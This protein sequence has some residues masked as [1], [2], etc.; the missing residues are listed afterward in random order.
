MSATTLVERRPRTRCQFEVDLLAGLQRRNKRIPSKYFYNTEGSRLFERV[1]E[2]SEYYPTR[3][4]ISILK[5][6][7]PEIAQLIGPDVEMIEFGAGSLRKVR[8]LLDVLRSPQ[9]YTPIDVAGEY[10]TEVAQTLEREYPSLDVTPVIADF[11]QPLELETSSFRRVGFL[12]GSTIGNFSPSQA[13]TLLRNIR[14]TLNNGGLL[15]G[16]DLVK[17]PSILH[18]AYNDVDGVTAS[19]NK[20]LLV[21]ANQELGADFNLDSFMHH[22]CYNPVS[23]KIEMYLVSVE[24]QRVRIADSVFNF[25]EGEAIH[26]EDSYKY[27]CDSFRTLAVEA[28]Y[29]PRALWTDQ[30]QSFSVQWLEAF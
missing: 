2:L 30:T 15:I 26:T 22:S 17:C 18:A 20:N 21:R 5:T 1:T 16:V 29:E 11:T 25:V 8:I 28:G 6:H 13:A 10:L 4:E 12:P 3:S 27:T 7:V 24:R 9:R 14:E 23:R 19:F